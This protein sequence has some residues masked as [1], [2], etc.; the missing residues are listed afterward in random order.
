MENILTYEEVKAHVLAEVPKECPICGGPLTLS[1]DLMHLTCDNPDCDGKVARK[2]EIAAKALGIDNVGPSAAKD[3]VD[4][5]GVHHVS[6]LYEFTVEDF[7]KIPRFQ[8]GLATNLYK[9][10]QGAKEVTF[11]QFIRACQFYRVGD[12]TSNDIANA[13]DT[14]DQFRNATADDLMQKV[15]GMTIDSARLIMESVK[16]AGEDVSRL[17]KYVG[18]KYPEKIQGSNPTGEILTCV[19]TGPLGFGSRPE[20]QRVFGD[21][22]G[23]KW[24]SSV[25]K[26]TD[27]L[28]TNESASTTKYKK[29][30]ELQAAGGKI[31]IMTEEEFL[32]YVGAPGTTAEA[33]Q[34]A[35]M[36]EYENLKSFDGVEVVL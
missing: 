19:V 28:V 5:L 21:A 18:I 14:L 13:Y 22:Y 6:Q 2:L 23:V 33:R 25:T 16:K 34:M 12:G 32:Q 4:H 20:F 29:A 11:A 7:L 3:L 31:K 9:S 35:N 17:E 1:D 27:I 26:N 15:G 10:V 8:G 36:Q 24:G 30:L